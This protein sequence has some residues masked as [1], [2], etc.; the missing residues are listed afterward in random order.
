MNS[1]NSQKQTIPTV[2]VVLGATGDLMTKKIVPALFNLHE[3]HALPPKFE[4]LGVSRR[5]WHDEE[6]R[7]HI[8]AILDV[9]APDAKRASVDS[10]LKLA[11]YHKITFDNFEDYVGLAQALKSVDDAWG[12]CTN[13]LFY[14][15][16]PP[17]FYGLI[18]ENIHKSHLADACSPEEGWTRIIIEKPFGDDEKTA[19]ALDAQLGKLFKE[20]QI[21]RV[22]HYL[23]KETF[24]NILAFRFANNLF[25][26]EWNNELIERIHFREYENVGAEDR[27]AFYD[28]VGALRDVGQN[29]LLQMLALTTMERPEDLGANAVRHARAELLQTLEPL[30]P[31]EIKRWT[32][33][34][35]YD[36]YRA[37]KGV[38]PRS[39]AETYFRARAYLSHP[40]WEG[41]PM[42]FEA[43]KRL[44]DP[45]E[46]KE[47]TEIEVIFRHPQPCLCPPEVAGEPRTH[48]RNSLVFHQDPKEGITLKFWSKK[49]GFGMELEERT[50]E[51]ER[52]GGR[53]TQYTEEYEKLLL[54][55]IAGD[56]SLFVSSEEIAAMWHFVDPI[57]NAWRKDAV[58]LKTYKPDNPAITAEAAVME[59][60]ADKAH[61]LAKKE[62]G[63]FGLG[64][65]GANVARQLREKGWR[66]VVS[67][68]SP[69]PLAA[70]A[71]EGFEAAPSPAELAEKLSG[72]NRGPRIFW[73]MITAGKGI[74]E[75]LFGAR[76]KGGLAEHLRKGDI[77]I[78]G[79]NSFFEDTVRRAK[80]LGKRGVRLMDVGFSGG[81]RGA[82]H[83]GSLMIGGD[84]KTYEY[85]EPLFADLSVPFGYAHFGDAGAGHFVKM[86]H[87]GIEYGMMQS[88]AEGFALMKKSPFKLDLAKVARVYQH[89]SVI[90]S[91]LVGWMEESFR[92]FGP[93][94]RAASGTVAATGEGEW[95]VK[96][97]R[98][99][100][101]KLPA[102]EDAF[103]FRVASKK[104]PSYMGKILS[105][106]RNRFGGHK[107]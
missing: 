1:E 103:K 37:I 14:L 5:D 19:R 49:P 30:T 43:G 16:F 59:E 80:L 20:E 40:R 50:F 38:S 105:A 73:L 65:M 47:V 34:A 67:N 36:G 98:T 4:L 60:T 58:P 93:D 46:K 62:I 71:A 55:C 75:Y 7:K 29:H 97:G 101:M 23:A 42:I 12:V 90:E 89:G 31:D 64:K 85:S 77:V 69:E 83:G 79:G 74:D 88:I 21:Y 53:K 94:L 3:K 54:D 10:F 41:V 95:T 15:S 107:L 87:N 32:F 39:Q 33:R 76:G 66:V 9:K 104:K 22:D 106:L 81:P 27:G 18:L 78:D 24:Q 99:W 45:R 25:E 86:V 17:Q 11:K 44:L 8:R 26:N 82:R 6:L 68:R 61:V 96:T 63:V 28:A 48:Y 35:Q 100:G 57:M 56:Q 51:F 72:S 84:R 92:V 13:K 102:I 91:R 70:L 52:S 2:L